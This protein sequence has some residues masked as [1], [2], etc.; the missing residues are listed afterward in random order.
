MVALDRQASGAAH[1]EPSSP[2]ISCDLDATEHREVRR[3]VRELLSGH[4]HDIVVD[5]AVL[6]T[7]ELVSNAHKHGR[8]P[9]ACRLM[10]VADGRRLRVE[11]DDAS[12]AQPQLRTPDLDG[13]RGLIL[14]DRLATVWGV[15]NAATHKTVWAE[16]TLD[17]AGSSGH[18]PH[19]AVT[20]E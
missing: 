12:A 5:D 10:L 20:P 14:V 9:R 17:H 3:L 7:A 18:A 1:G 16:L 13:G 15:H 19:L 11:V 4:N 6:V 8:A 2:N